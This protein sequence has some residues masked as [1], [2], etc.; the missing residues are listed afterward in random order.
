MIRRR[1]GDPSNYPARAHAVRKAADLSHPAPP[2]SP[3]P[4]QRAREDRWAGQG[5]DTCDQGVPCDST[6]QLVDA[7]R[8]LLLRSPRA[9]QERSFS[10]VA[11]L[12]GGGIPEKCGSAVAGRA[13]AAVREN[14]D[15]RGDFVEFIFI[16]QWISLLSW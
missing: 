8:E 14:G 1:P 6:C 2:S 11:S 16:Y 4:G 10:Y 3:A 15:T 5:G 9:Q 7:V 13:N 12:L